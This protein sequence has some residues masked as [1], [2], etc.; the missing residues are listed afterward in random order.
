VLQH[1]LGD[2]RVLPESLVV[3][4]YLDN[5]YPEN[6]LQPV[7]AFTNAYHKLLIER[8]SK[9][10]TCFYKLMLT[11]ESTAAKDLSE[12]LKFYENVLAGDFFGGKILFGNKFI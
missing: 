2:E 3:S 5:L 1:G 8:F 9:V 12:S 10:T 4:E 11:N 7:D 6:R